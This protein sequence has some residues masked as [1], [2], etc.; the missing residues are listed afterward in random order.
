[1]GQT[2]KS[3]HTIHRAKA[4]LFGSRERLIIGTDYMPEYD[5]HIDTIYV[6]D[7]YGK[8]F[9]GVIKWSTDANG[10]LRLGDVI[11]NSSGYRYSM[12]NGDTWADYNIAFGLRTHGVHAMLPAPDG[13]IFL[14]AY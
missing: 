11:L 7:D 3:E 12:D 14:C 1:K 10:L 5:V 8:S 13:R 6:S 4:V 2:W 9:R